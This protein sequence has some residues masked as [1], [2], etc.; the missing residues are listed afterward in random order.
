MVTED[1]EAGARAC[2]QNSSLVIR[3]IPTL[4]DPGPMELKI[5]KM[6]DIIV[7]LRPYVQESWPQKTCHK[8]TCPKFRNRASSSKFLPSRLKVLEIFLITTLY[9]LLVNHL[10]QL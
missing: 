3:H 7:G 8:K 2:K 9:G 4:V 5:R 1:R 10:T 6:L